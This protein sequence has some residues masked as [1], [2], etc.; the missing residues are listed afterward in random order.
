MQKDNVNAGRKNEPVPLQC[1]VENDGWR[2]KLDELDGLESEEGTVRC[3][4]PIS[5]H[6]FPIL[7]NFQFSDL[8]ISIDLHLFLVA[9]HQTVPLYVDLWSRPIFFLK[10]LQD[11]LYLMGI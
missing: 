6:I 10:F 4:G 8:E 9:Q 2:G 7:A 1:Q 3:D 5:Q 11:R